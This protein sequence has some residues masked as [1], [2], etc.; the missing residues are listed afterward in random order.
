MPVQVM[1]VTDPVFRTTSVIA[2]NTAVSSAAIN[3]SKIGPRGLAVFVAA[4]AWT[5]ANIGFDVSADGTTWYTLCKGDQTSRVPVMITGISTSVAGLYVAPAETIAVGSWP[6][7]R[8]TS[9]NT[10]TYAA[11]NQGGERTLIISFFG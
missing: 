2:N 5:A 9:L 10:S 4:G 8:L 7:M 3:I 6:Y 11:A 1:N